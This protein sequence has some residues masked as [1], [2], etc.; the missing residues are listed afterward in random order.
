MLVIKISLVFNPSNY[1]QV[2]T[3]LLHYRRN[4][5]I[6]YWLKFGY[7]TTIPIQILPMAL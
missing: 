4:K 1:L 5:V 2:V 6:V 3:E 7:E